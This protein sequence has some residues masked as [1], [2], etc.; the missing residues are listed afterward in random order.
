MLRSW[1]EIAA[2]LKVS[3]R[4]AQRWKWEFGLP[5]HRMEGEHESGILAFPDEIEQWLKDRLG[6]IEGQTARADPEGPEVELEDVIITD[7]LWNRPSRPPAYEQEIQA[8]RILV[9]TIAKEEPR[10]VIGTISQCAL[11]LC[12]AESSGFS[13]LERDVEG[14]EIFRF[15]AV[16]GILQKFDGRTARR[17]FS[18]YA[19]CIERNSPQLFRHPEKYYPYLQ[20]AGPIMEILLVPAHSATGG[21]GTMWVVSH[22]EKRKFDREDIRIVESLAEIASTVV[23]AKS[24]AES[25]K[26]TER[27]KAKGKAAGSFL[28]FLP[29]LHSGLF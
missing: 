2:H 11:D 4:T 13:L 3:V 20:E 27:L 24:R 8:L 29:L 1:K 15:V 23:T 28:A 6:R 21:T 26:N 5:V 17:N 10:D 18:P 9:R 12:K 25:P 14:K 22:T 16:K 19:I 7:Q